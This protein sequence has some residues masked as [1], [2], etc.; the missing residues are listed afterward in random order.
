MLLPLYYIFK[1]RGLARF[2]FSNGLFLAGMLLVVLPWT[3]RNYLVS[4]HFIPISANG[5]FNLLISFSEESTGAYIFNLDKQAGHVYDWDSNRLVGLAWSEYEIDQF[6][7]KAALS[8]IRKEPL[9]SVSLAPKK[10]FF[11]LRDDVSAVYDNLFREST[12]LLPERYYPLYWLLRVG[13]QAYYMAML[14]L[15]LIG[16]SWQRPFKESPALLF[17]ALPLIFLVVFHLVFFG[18]DRFHMPF[19]PLFWAFSSL[20][21]LRLSGIIQRS[22]VRKYLPLVRILQRR[23]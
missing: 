21:V 12:F 16:A 4:G 5:G 19:L 15:V 14:G 22:I 20:G 9:R 23:A 6:A 17:L 11:L 10:L 3:A 8:Y 2:V 13:A 18:D 1:C 7:S